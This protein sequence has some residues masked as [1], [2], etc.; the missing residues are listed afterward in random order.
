L[1]LFVELVQNPER[2]DD[3][4]RWSFLRDDDPYRG[5]PA[6]GSLQGGEGRP[7]Q[8]WFTWDGWNFS[9]VCFLKEPEEA[10]GLV[11]ELTGHLG[12]VSRDAD[13]NGLRRMERHLEEVSAHSQ[14]PIPE[15]MDE[16][17]HA[18]LRR[19]HGQQCGLRVAWPFPEPPIRH[20]GSTFLGVWP[21][22]SGRPGVWITMDAGSTFS[23]VAFYSQ[24]LDAH[25]AMLAL[26]QAIKQGGFASA[27]R[28]EALLLEAVNR[29]E[30]PVPA[31]MGEETAA[32]I[33]ED[34]EASVALAGWEAPAYRRDL[35]LFRLFYESNTRQAT[36]TLQS[37]Y[38][39]LNSGHLVIEGYDPY[40]LQ[41]L[42]VLQRM[43][44]LKHARIFYLEPSGLKLLEALA[45]PSTELLEFPAEPMWIQPLAPL[46]FRHGLVRGIFVYDGFNTG[47]I[48][49]LPIRNPTEKA[50]A[51]SYSERKH[52]MHQV[53]IFYDNPQN[54]TKLWQGKTLM[55]GEY[56][57]RRQSWNRIA[58]GYE[59]PSGRCSVETLGEQS[60]LLQCDECQREFAHWTQ[61]FEVF[62][63]GIQG[64]LRRAEDTS[65][66]E[67]FDLPFEEEQQGAPGSKRHKGRPGGGK[68]RAYHAT[69]VRYDASYFKPVRS[70]G[71]RGPL[72]DSHIVLTTEEALR[73]GALELDMDGVL[74]RDT[75]PRAAF[76]RHF[77]HPRYKKAEA[78]VNF[79][80]DK[81]QLVSLATWKARRMPPHEALHRQ[82]DVYASVYE[83]QP[84]AETRSDSRGQD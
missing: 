55:F 42:C 45:S 61:W 1:L 62:V 65:S 30:S 7:W 38:Q 67:E 16:Q 81:P 2:A 69:V 59:C 28:A 83:E 52:G 34:F 8:V 6:V 68:V 78:H 82:E 56:D 47:R 26:S 79:R 12:E 64:K 72:R 5:A 19:R 43:F 15:E 31:K 77:V 27:E 63:L 36:T 76:T 53:E 10:R 9:W 58:E 24:A 70:R 20:L 57:T 32:A 51:R 29:S 50:L 13:D 54:R 3:M 40:L 11:D 60:V 17:I 23:W 73:E 22:P 25:W 71:R 49:L 35:A 18:G 4:A 46:P 39:A 44:C 21:A 66:F 74:I 37:M 80:P 14:Y 48:D 33:R 84:G 41:E 75:A